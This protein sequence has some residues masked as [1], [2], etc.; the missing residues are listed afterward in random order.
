MTAV[1]GLHRGGVALTVP[2]LGLIAALLPTS[3]EALS[4]K[5][6]DAFAQAIT[7]GCVKGLEDANA[8]Y[9]AAAIRGYCTCT[10][11]RTARELDD[12]DMADFAASGG[13]AT[14]A[15]RSMTTRIGKA[16][17]DKHLR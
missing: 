10:G 2:A 11:E 16:C 15:L 9:S 13:E 14:P 8:P 17:S 4:G 6:A 5:R 3:A 1:H 7:T 12:S